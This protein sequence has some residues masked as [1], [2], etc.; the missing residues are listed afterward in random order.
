MPNKAY[1]EV[2]QW[3]GKEM[4][5]LGLGLL[6]VLAV[7]LRQPDSRQVTPFKHALYCVRS[8]VDFNMIAQYQSQTPVTIAYMEAYLNQFHRMTDI[9]L[10]FQ[11]SKRTRAK[12][13]K[14]RKEVRH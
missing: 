4:R 7:A 8:L 13:D 11:V 9:F 2:T 3:Q 1:G 6:G 12:V 10:E 5:N 14:Q